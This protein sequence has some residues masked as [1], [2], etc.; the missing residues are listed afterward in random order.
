[1]RILFLLLATL[2]PAAASAGAVDLAELPGSGAPVQGGGALRGRRRRHSTR[3]ASRTAA[4]R[5]NSERVRLA[6]A[7]SRS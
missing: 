1:M 2:A 6:L 7:P 4:A 5:P 3:S